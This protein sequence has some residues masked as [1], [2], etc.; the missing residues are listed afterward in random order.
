VVKEKEYDKI[1]TALK[2]KND[3]KTEDGT[4]QMRTYNFINQQL[5][6]MR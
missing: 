2:Q 1:F 3:F 5:E 6:K 4:T